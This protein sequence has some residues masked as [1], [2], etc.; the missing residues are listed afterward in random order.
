MKVLR[1]KIRGSPFLGVFC[2][3]GGKTGIFPK[4][5]PES[6]IRALENALGIRAVKASIAESSVLGALAKIREEKIVVPEITEDC[7]VKEMEDNG[8]EV[9]VVQGNPALGN[10]IAVAGE[11]AVISPSF[12]A[13]QAKQIEKGLGVKAKKMSVGGTGLAGSSIIANKHGFA[14]TPRATKKEYGAIAGFFGIEGKPCTAN[15]GDSF[16]ANSVI[17]NDN[18]IIAGE[19]TS[20]VEITRLQEALED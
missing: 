10:L 8:L 9:T 18:A 19:Y 17:A 7:E 15:F 11:K 2:S 20:N 12:T 3:S 16:I 6:E 4:N 14:I 1:A 13:K 5:A